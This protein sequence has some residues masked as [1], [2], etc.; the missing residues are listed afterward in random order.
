MALIVRQAVAGTMESSDAY[1]EIEPA[2]AGVSLEIDSVVG[3]RFGESI[4]ASA[5][6][7]LR[8]FAVENARVRI[9]DQG[10]LDCVIRARVETAVRRGMEA[11]K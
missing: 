7:I 6:E 4:R 10:A 1:V 8:E 3:A 5:E 9:V 2:E 11:A